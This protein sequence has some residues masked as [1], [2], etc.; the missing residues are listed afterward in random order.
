MTANKLLLWMSAR[1]QGSWQQFRAAI[2]QLH[3]SE[4]E[5]DDKQGAEDDARD[6]HVLPLYQGLRLNLQRLGHAE[7]F[8]GAG[9]N[10]WR[11]A[12]PS[13][14]ATKQLDGWLGI[15]AGARSPSVLRRID[16]ATS[17]ETLKSVSV[18]ACPDHIKL[19][20]DDL[21]PMTAIANQ[22][23]LLFQQHA[24]Q[25]ILASLPPVD[26]PS[27]RRIRPTAIPMNWSGNT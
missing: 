11:V 19:F 26:H 23:G 24:P 12:P 16:N 13:L 5:S 17:K 22:A 4:S 25:A 8:A 6:T 20:T 14:A 27:V 18:P 2:E 15:V 21:Q 1:G 9:S 10:E 7:F 3:I